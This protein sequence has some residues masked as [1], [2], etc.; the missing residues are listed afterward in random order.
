MELEVSGEL[1][2]GQSVFAL[3]LL[4]DEDKTCSELQIDI[5]G[6]RAQWNDAVAGTLSS[7][8]PSARE[9]IEAK[10]AGEAGA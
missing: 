7:S 5:A 1:I 2:K 6:G 8:I 4:N 3:Q 9:I 10:R